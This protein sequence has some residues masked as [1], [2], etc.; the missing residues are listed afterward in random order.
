[1]RSVIICKR[2]FRSLG[3][4][5]TIKIALRHRQ[6]VSAHFVAARTLPQGEPINVSQARR[7]IASADG[8]LRLPFGA[9]ISRSRKRVSPGISDVGSLHPYLKTLTHGMTPGPSSSIVVK[10]G[11]KPTDLEV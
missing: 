2:V 11:K 7:M 9:T 4:L 6:C 5:A 10:S 3:H 1:V 8:G